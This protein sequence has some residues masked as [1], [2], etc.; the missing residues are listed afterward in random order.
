MAEEKVADV[1]PK[2]LGML[3]SVDELPL[4]MIDVVLVALELGLE[5]V[6]GITN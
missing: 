3:D 2:E 5:V 1:V 4:E 6:E